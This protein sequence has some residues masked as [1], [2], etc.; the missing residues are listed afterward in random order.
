MPELPEVETI[1]LGLQKHL[2]GHTITNVVVLTPSIVNGDMKR[3]VGAQVS[4]I[5]R[6][7]KGL[8][9]DFDNGYSMA[10]HVKM[11]GRLIYGGPVAR[12]PHPTSSP[13]LRAL[14]GGAPTH[15]TPHLEN[16]PKHTHVVFSLDKDA[17][18]YY[19]DIRRFG[20]IK[21]LPTEQV[22]ALPFF[23]N[24]GFEPLKNLTQ[25]KFEKLLKRYKTPIKS[26]LMD[27]AKIAGVGNI[28]ANDS[29]YHAQIHPMRVSSSLT[30]EEAVRLLGALE[31]ILRKSIAVG[32]A[33]ANNY[34]NALGEQGAYQEY[35][36]VYQKD[37]QV[38]KRCKSIIKRIKTAGRSTFFCPFCQRSS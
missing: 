25:D 20:W 11:T 19:N 9:I 26:L 34:V 10:V 3:A 6:F 31:E 28:Y 7:G 8:V 27:Q 1:K 38:C 24:L 36:L 15:A 14:D 4:A 13:S 32:G 22:G 17:V 29:L 33:S 23:K 37:G 12:Y 18:L 35:F 30:E 16:L 21:M 2:V 5:R